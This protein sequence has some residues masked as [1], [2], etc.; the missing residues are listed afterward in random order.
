MRLPVT[1]LHPSSLDLPPHAVS[2]V[3]R[4]FARTCTNAVPPAENRVPYSPRMDSLDA[5]LPRVL[6][7]RN[8]QSPSWRDIGT[9]LDPDEDADLETSDV[10][11]R[12]PQPPEVSPAGPPPAWPLPLPPLPPVSL[13]DAS[14]SLASP[15]RP[16]PL[17]PAR[18]RRGPSA[19]RRA[20]GAWEISP[21][22][23]TVAYTGALEVPRT[24]HR[25]S[26]PEW[27]GPG[28]RPP[29]GHRR[30]TVALETAAR[31]LRE[32]EGESRAA[33][34]WDGYPPAILDAYAS[35]SEPSPAAASRKPRNEGWRTPQAP[36]RTP[37]RPPLALR[38]SSNDS[39]AQD[40]GRTPLSEDVIGSLARELEAS[41]R[42]RRWQ[43][44]RSHSRTSGIR[45]SAGDG[46]MD[47]SG[48][49]GE[50]TERRR[51]NTTPQ[52][53]VKHQLD[54]DCVDGGLSDD[55]EES[56]LL[57]VRAC[58]PK[59][60]ARSVL[61]AGSIVCPMPRRSKPARMF[62]GDN[63]GGNDP[64][65]T[66]AKS[67]WSWVWSSTGKGEDNGSGDHFG[68]NSD[69]R[70]A[71]AAKPASPGSESPAVVPT[72][73]VRRAADPRREVAILY[74]A[75]LTRNPRS[76]GFS[77]SRRESGLGAVSSDSREN[78]M[79]AGGNLHEHSPCQNVA[80]RADRMWRELTMVPAP[81][82][83]TASV[84]DVSVPLVRSGPGP[85]VGSPRVA[86]RNRTGGSPK[87]SAVAQ[88]CGL[89]GPPPPP[90]P[91]P[92]PLN[93]LA[94]ALSPATKRARRT[95]MVVSTGRGRFKV[96]KP[97][98]GERGYGRQRMAGA[99]RSGF[100]SGEGSVFL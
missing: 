47:I 88:R 32:H 29:D 95:G 96:A 46:A 78:A 98:G 62:P 42:R 38:L 89:M 63:A 45:F 97:E 33:S 22:D 26:P 25:A 65:Q 8:Q 12:A 40:P 60:R 82:Q 18:V 50:R 49:R 80:L 23:R 87:W 5:S 9:F 41:P 30:T 44:R 48:T 74:K 81:P 35:S 52:T 75:R 27:R 64:P 90:P 86:C 69:E 100:G 16:S 34:P 76:Y 10:S 17:L 66:P 28:P 2:P 99:M 21:R 59:S 72:T 14:A 36:L 70:D 11:A 7:V 77:S 85:A 61:K 54:G 79:S 57:R 91:V 58:R 56:P 3:R 51:A 6:G 19:K 73:P 24:R 1:I 83:A 43:P 84:G 37:P 71:C 55:N 67:S 15:F 4:A 68:K 93:P 13:V 94:P 39:N 92:P 53:A 31:D 20:A